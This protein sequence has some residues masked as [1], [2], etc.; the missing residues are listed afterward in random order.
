MQR[1][2]AAAADFAERFDAL[3]NARREADADVADA[4]RAIIGRVRDAS[5]SCS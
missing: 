2:D 5:S 3:V 1:L 4:V